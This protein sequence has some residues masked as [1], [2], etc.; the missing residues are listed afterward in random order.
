MWYLSDF[1]V[2][3]RA[4]GL[5]DQDPHWIEDMRLCLRLLSYQRQPIPNVAL[6]ALANR[7]G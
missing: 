6:E 1:K 7:H 5:D 4:G 2:M 3:P